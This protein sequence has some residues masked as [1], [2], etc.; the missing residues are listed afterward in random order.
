MLLLRC[1]VLYTNI[2]HCLRLDQL[3]HTNQ[4][5]QLNAVKCFWM[6]RPT[7]PCIIFDIPAFLEFC[8]RV[9][10]ANFISQKN[11]NSSSFHF[12][13]FKKEVKC[14]TSRQT[15][16][17][18]NAKTFLKKKG[19]KRATLETEKKFRASPRCFL[20]QVQE[21][22]LLCY[23]VSK[24]LTYSAETPP[25]Y[26][27]HLHQKTKCRLYLHDLL[28]VVS[29]TTKIT[30]FDILSESRKLEMMFAP[31]LIRSIM[32]YYAQH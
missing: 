11:S 27:L 32:Q 18:R 25:P 30:D 24:L 7:L 2:T 28:H 16:I 14:L 29:L 5:N 13:L 9:S 3:K 8:D 6:T 26:L 19:K 10:F 22:V 20:P 1:R 23:F 15:K 17:F 12:Y 4:L 31:V 21:Q